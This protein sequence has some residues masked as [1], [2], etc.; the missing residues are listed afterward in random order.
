MTTDATVSPGNGSF[1]NIC[2]LPGYFPMRLVVVFG[3]QTTAED[4]LATVKSAF[5]KYDGSKDGYVRPP[6]TKENAYFQP[7]SET[8]LIWFSSLLPP[9]GIVAHEAFHA[10]HDMLPEAGVPFRGDSVTHEVYAYAVGSLVEQI[11][12]MRP[13]Q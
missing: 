1:I 11:M 10:V 3:H 2:T 12:A 9:A 4:V 13:G 5:P 8:A 7:L 6:N